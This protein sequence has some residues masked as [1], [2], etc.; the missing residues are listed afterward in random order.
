M[1]ENECKKELKQDASIYNR[2]H[3][4]SGRILTAS[5]YLLILSFVMLLPTIYAAQPI[6]YLSNFGGTGYGDGQFKAPSGIALD[7]SG[8]IYVVD[9][10]N[11]V[12]VFDSKGKYLSNFGG[13]GYGDGQFKAPSGIALDSSGNI[14]VTDTG[15]N[16]VEEFS[17]L[18]NNIAAST[19]PQKFANNGTSSGTNSS[20]S[21]VGNKTSFINNGGTSEVMNLTKSQSVV[22][23]GWIKNNAKWWSQGQLGDDDFVKGIQ[24]LIQEGIMKIPHGQTGAN[25]SHKIP[26]WVKNNAGWWAD[27][28]ISDDDFVKGIQY[29]ITNGLIKI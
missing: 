11:N 20:G 28:Q 24:Y 29:L 25:S 22:I 16:R 12:Q 26:L 21:A 5:T 17:A 14:Y 10:I 6:S 9:A 7:S 27:G 23:P 8:N 2:L 13:T 4:D 3:A 1:K 19:I 15:N 18:K